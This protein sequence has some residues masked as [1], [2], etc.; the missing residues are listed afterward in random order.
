MRLGI[1]LFG[2]GCLIVL[3]ECIETEQTAFANVGAGVQCTGRIE[4]H[5]SEGF[6]K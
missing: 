2:L 3:G 4:L 6:H 5:H 1:I